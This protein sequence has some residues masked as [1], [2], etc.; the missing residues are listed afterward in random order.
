L[1]HDLLGG[2]VDSFSSLETLAVF[3]DVTFTG[4]SGRESAAERMAGVSWV[5][6]D[7]LTILAEGVGSSS[8]MG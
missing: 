3:P 5:E 8:G 6:E 7:G 2:F 1:T 4:G